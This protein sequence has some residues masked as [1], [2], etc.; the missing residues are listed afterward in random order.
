MVKKAVRDAIIAAAK[1]KHK[2]ELFLA[3]Y[4]FLDRHGKTVDLCFAYREPSGA[5]LQA[6]SEMLQRDGIEANRWLMVQIVVSTEGDVPILEIVGAHNMAVS[7]FVAEY[8]NPLFGKVLDTRP[9]QN[10]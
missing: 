8:V 4:S 3:E 6:Y 9:R 7:T 2:G 1:E 5:E 10:L